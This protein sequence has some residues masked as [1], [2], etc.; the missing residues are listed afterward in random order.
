MVFNIYRL[1][2]KNKRTMTFHFRNFERH[3]AKMEEAGK[4]LLI[5]AQRWCLRCLDSALLS[6]GLWSPMG[7]TLEVLV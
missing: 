1:V 5:R 7:H 4:T 3:G 6:S 2:P